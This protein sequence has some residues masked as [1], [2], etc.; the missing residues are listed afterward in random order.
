MDKYYR[1]SEN[2]NSFWLVTFALIIY[3]K[4]KKKVKGK[5][6]LCM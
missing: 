5:K 6:Y 1:Y 2:S 4:K 3:E